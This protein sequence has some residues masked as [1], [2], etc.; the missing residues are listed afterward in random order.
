MRKQKNIVWMSAVIMACMATVFLVPQIVTAG[1]LEPPA[2]ALDGS[3][4]PVA[5]TMTPPS[6]SQ[7]LPVS[8]RFKIIEGESIYS[9]AVLD[10]QTGLVWQKDAGAGG[11][12]KWYDAVTSCYKVRTGSLLGWR[13]PTIEELTSLLSPQNSSPYLDVLP[14][15]HPFVNVGATYWSISTDPGGATCATEAYV[16]NI[17]SVPL[18]SDLDKNESIGIWC[19]LGGNG[20]DARAYSSGFNLPNYYCP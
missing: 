10:K 2:S 20:H 1:S 13:L 9:D 19:V 16:L 5:T 17:G 11:A 14:D 7:K 6:W 4:N 18:I 8:E 3:G 12:A 15:G